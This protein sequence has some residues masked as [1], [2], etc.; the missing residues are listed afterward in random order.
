MRFYEANVLVRPDVSVSQM[1]SDFKKLASSLA[2]KNVRVSRAEYCGFRTLAYRLAKRRKAHYVLINFMAPEESS[3]AL[4]ELSYWLKFHR[5][6]VRSLVVRVEKDAEGVSP[7]YDADLF[8]ESFGTPRTVGSDDDDSYTQSFGDKKAEEGRSGSAVDKREVVVSEDIDYKNVR[9]LQ[10]FVT[11]S[12]RIMPSRMSQLARKRQ[13]DLALAIK[14]ARFLALM[15][16]V[17]G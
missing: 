6:V 11:E 5:D 10:R 16:Y 4:S 9:F 14:R 3:E 7:L 2:E 15:P 17:M 8:S 1:K 13:A 12:G